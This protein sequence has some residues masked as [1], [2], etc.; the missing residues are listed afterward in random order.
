M[1]PW[2]KDILM[3]I[4]LI[5][6]VLLILAAVLGFVGFILTCFHVIRIG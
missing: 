6:L 3:K 5:F 1:N 2:I 4:L